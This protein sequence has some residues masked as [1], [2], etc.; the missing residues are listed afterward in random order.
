MEDRKDLK[1]LCDFDTHVQR[2]LEEASRKV[3]Q[4]IRD[5]DARVEAKFDRLEGKVRAFELILKDVSTHT[6]SKDKELSQ[7]AKE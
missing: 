5:S 7:F 4:K 3:E 6:H 1:V 2:K